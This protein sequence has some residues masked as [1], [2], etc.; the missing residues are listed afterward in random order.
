MAPGSARNRIAVHTVQQFNLNKNMKTKIISFIAFPLFV[1][2]AAYAQAITW[3]PA[4]P[5]NKAR[6]F[7]VAVE[8]LNGNVL[9]VGGYDG[10][11]DPRTGTWSDAGSMTDP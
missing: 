4:N 11:L 2:A 10:I 3:T 7:F 5:M 1:C 9:V 8:L 6:A